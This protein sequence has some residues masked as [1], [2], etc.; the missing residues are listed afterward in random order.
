MVNTVVFTIIMFYFDKNLINKEKMDPS[1]E[2]SL[3]LSETLD[4]L[5]HLIHS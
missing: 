3:N 2:L 5:I 4:I 1:E